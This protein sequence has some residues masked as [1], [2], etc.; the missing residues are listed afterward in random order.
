MDQTSEVDDRQVVIMR[1]N[2]QEDEDWIV[3]WNR[4]A[5]SL[6]AYDKEEE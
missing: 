3:A 4:R 6:R 5:D 2:V 1:S